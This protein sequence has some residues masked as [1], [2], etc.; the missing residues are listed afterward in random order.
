MDQKRPAIRRYRLSSLTVED[1]AQIKAHLSQGT[2]PASLA[3]HFNVHHRTV[4]RIRDG[5]SWQSVAP[6]SNALPLSL[7]FSK[8]MKRI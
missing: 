5:K 6:A 8:I 7:S 2:T 3:R 4:C 1:V